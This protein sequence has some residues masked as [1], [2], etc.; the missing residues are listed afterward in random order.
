MSLLFQYYPE[1]FSAVQGR[2]LYLSTMSF[3]QYTNLAVHMSLLRL[4]L[5]QLQ[6]FLR[7]KMP[8]LGS[9]ATSNR[10]VPHTKV[11]LFRILST[12]KG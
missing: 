3:R 2:N 4:H 11:S 7:S 9:V 12:T 10:Q 6:G 5:H 8:L 1:C